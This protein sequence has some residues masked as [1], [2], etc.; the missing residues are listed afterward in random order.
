MADYKNNKYLNNI[1]T[2]DNKKSS[3]EN[4]KVD[5][6]KINSSDPYEALQTENALKDMISK[7]K[8]NKDISYS[9]DPNEDLEEK[10]EASNKNTSSSNSSSSS[11]SNMDFVSLKDLLIGEGYI[12]GE[13]A[14]E[15][16]KKS[17]N[18]YTIKK[19]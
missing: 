9:Y 4:V 8:G 6:S 15:L 17:G 2:I 1:E 16:R 18:K 5:L 13:K 11:S 19:D 12:K 7:L 3:N 10:H 14:N